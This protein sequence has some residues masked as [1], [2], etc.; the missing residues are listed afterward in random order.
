MLCLAP[1][2][3]SSG[4]NEEPQNTAGKGVST[5]SSKANQASS[6]AAVDQQPQFV[7]RQQLRVVREILIYEHCAMSAPHS[8][9]SGTNE[10]L[11]STADKRVSTRNSKANPA[12]SVASV[13]QQP[14]HVS[15]QLP[16]G[17]GF[18]FRFRV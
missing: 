14:Q 5:R 4:T 13:D 1:H 9:C 15:Q 11:K 8:S 7:A 16:K 3:S 10:E 18:R 6:F 17:L 12:S 2:S